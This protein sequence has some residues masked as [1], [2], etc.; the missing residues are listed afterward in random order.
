MQLHT[1]FTGATEQMVSQHLFEIIQFMPMT[2]DHRHARRNVFGAH[3]MT[4]LSMLLCVLVSNMSHVVYCC[5]TN[6]FPQMMMLPS[7][8]F[9]WITDDALAR[10][11]TH[12][13]RKAS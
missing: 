6:R 12:T 8:S 1:H 3:I 4:A 11:H 2:A 5:A 9:V 13:P 10:T 7:P